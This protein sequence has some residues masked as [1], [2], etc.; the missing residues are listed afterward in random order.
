M[1]LPL[2]PEALMPL[3]APTNNDVKENKL[4][5]NLK[6]YS[7]GEINSLT[8]QSAQSPDTIGTTRLKRSRL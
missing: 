2:C 6:Q 5:P 8:R 7:Y 4:M 1:S 3:R